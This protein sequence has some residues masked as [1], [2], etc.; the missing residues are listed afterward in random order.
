[1]I[2]T[3]YYTACSLDGFIAGPDHD[4]AWLLQFGEAEG[5]SYPDFIRHV[6]AVAMGSHTYEWILR[7]Q[8]GSESGPQRPWPYQQPCWVFTT[9][10]LQTIP[11]A[12]IRFARGDIRA[13]HTAMV[14]ASGGRNVWV[15]GGGELAAQFYD[16]GLLDE[17]IV[18]FAPVAL[19]GGFPLLPRAITSPP[20]RLL[21]VTTYGV[22]VELRYEVPSRAEA[23]DAEP[24]AAADRGRM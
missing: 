18:T 13:A 1:V 8:V 4:L 17:V 2:R 5:T 10:T 24:G 9:R 23:R 3:Q 20:L 15:V 6:G 12:D 14:A 7:H 16:A 11:G 22:F 21:G 19:G